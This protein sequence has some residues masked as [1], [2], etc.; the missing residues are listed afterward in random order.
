[1]TES[2]TAMLD[3][4]RPAAQDRHPPKDPVALPL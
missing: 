4:K 3:W 2:T 1:M